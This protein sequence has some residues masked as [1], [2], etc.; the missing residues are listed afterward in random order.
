ML[1]LPYAL[2]YIP[3]LAT[4]HYTS[5]CACIDLNSMGDEASTF[6]GSG[7]RA[8]IKENHYDF[9]H[10]LLLDFRPLEQTSAGILQLA[11]IEIDTNAVKRNV[12][13]MVSALS[14]RDTQGL[15]TY[16]GAFCDTEWLISD[17]NTQFPGFPGS[18]LRKTVV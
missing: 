13:V 4:P 14:V 9:S 15:E 18:L 8:I 7:R 10:P 2:R 6:S 12:A 17:F 11:R 16:L 1:V 5:P 3:A